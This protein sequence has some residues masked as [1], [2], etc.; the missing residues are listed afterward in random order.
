MA[1]PIFHLEPKYWQPACSIRRERI[2]YFDKWIG[3]GS[4]KSDN[5]RQP[6][7]NKSQGEVSRKAA[8]R[9][10]KVVELLYD[11]A[12]KKRVYS[13][14]K[15]SYFYYKIG[16]LTI[17]LPSK[18]IHTDNE[19]HRSC[20]QPFIKFIRRKRPDFLYLYKAETQ[21]NGNLHYHIT[22]NSFLHKDFINTTWN[23]YV[24]KLGY[25]DRFGRPNPPSTEIRAVKNEKDLSIYLSKYLSKNNDERRKVD[26]KTWDCSLELKKVNISCKLDWEMEFEA[27]ENMNQSN[28][29]FDGMS[30][31]P[32][33]KPIQVICH[34]F[35]EKERKQMPATN[36]IYTKAIASILAT[37]KQ[38]NSI[39]YV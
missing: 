33:L 22:T 23:Y 20:F 31:E 37:T 8:I 24:N 21:A 29:I 28:L 15:G 5:I 38:E 7:S 11:C 26:I 17:T 16:F 36:E 6:I 1:T 12:K 13:K 18:Q 27:K 32:P 3:G 25:C 34:N 30:F 10:S 2:Y 39:F 19:I 4:K 9:I 35:K 14:E